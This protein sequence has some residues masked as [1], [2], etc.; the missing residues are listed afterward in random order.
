MSSYK[1]KSIKQVVCFLLVIGIVTSSLSGCGQAKTTKQEKKVTGTLNAEVAKVGTDKLSLDMG[2]FPLASEAECVIKPVDAPALEGVDIVAYD[3]SIDTEEELFPVMKLTMPY[4]VDELGGKEPEGRIG[5]AYFNEDTKEWEPVSFDINKDQGTITI[6][7][8]HLSIYGCFAIEN[9]NKRGAYIDYV[10]PSFA[11]D[12]VDLTLANNIIINAVKNGGNPQDDAVDLGLTTLD[13]LLSIG[14]AGVSTISQAKESLSGMMG[15]AKGLSLYAEVGKM[16]DT[17]GLA[18]SVAQV[19]RGM[20]NINYGTSKEIFPCYSDALKGSYSYVT[21][22]AGMHLASLAFLGTMMIDYSITSFAEAAIQGRKDIYAKAYSMYYESNEVKRNV[23][24]WAKVFMDARKTASSAERYGLR[25]EGLV[26]RY[27]DQFW[28][29]E[30]A[31]AQYQDLAMKQGF[32]GGGGL[33]EQ[34]K[35]EISESYKNELYRGIIQDAFR[36][37]A[38]KDYKNADNEVRKILNKTKKELNKICTIE[39]YDGS[40]ADTNKNSE[41]ADM[42]VYLDVPDNIVDPELWS[43]SLDK[44]GNGK[45]QFTA[46]AYLWADQPTE[47]K[48]Y[49]KGKSKDEEPDTT[50]SFTMTDIV[51]KVDIGVVGVPLEELIGEYEGFKEIISINLTDD[52]YQAYLDMEPE[53][54]TSK[55]ECDEAVWSLY[56]EEQESSPL[57]AVKITITSEDITSGLCSINGIIENNN[58][59]QTMSIDCEYKGGSLDLKG[60]EEKTIITPIKE[61]DGTIRIKGDKMVFALKDPETGKSL[62]KIG[63]SFD[64][65]KVQ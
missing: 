47:L 15:T 1:N 10:I 43:S 51:Q 56:L 25:I 58:G 5:A 12:G 11:T 62:Y 60:Q 30:L 45:I 21:G 52:G 9:E 48:L 33:N 24:D 49:E 65:T 31:I 64:L 6:N 2:D 22:K 4:N 16:I 3:F 26:Q 36:L 14:D 23:K 59:P 41:M 20:S 54:V 38:E 55:A 53:T 46:L 57:N 34:I 61:A 40:I 27:V 32:T 18:V 44:K 17:L 29:D 13:T 50:I 39:L 8:D 19:A 28:K 42:Q 35:T 63:L 37:I 7:T